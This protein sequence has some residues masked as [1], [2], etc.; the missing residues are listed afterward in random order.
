[1]FNKI[2][3]PETGKWVDIH[4]QAGKRV[5]NNYINQSGEKLSGGGMFDGIVSMMNDTFKSVTGIDLV[6]VQKKDNSL[7]LETLNNSQKND[8]HEKDDNVDQPSFS[9]D[10]IK[11][12]GGRKKGSRS[13]KT[14]RR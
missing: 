1:M 6:T 8:D 13:K 7:N 4:G 10:S 11:Q 5:L 2:K 9:N 14:S 12:T 3:N